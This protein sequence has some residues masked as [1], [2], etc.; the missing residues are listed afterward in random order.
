MTP[1]DTPP[2][3]ATPRSP[4]DLAR[5]EGVTREAVLVN[6]QVLAP[7]IPV[8]LAHVLQGSAPAL[9]GDEQ[10]AGTFVHEE[11]DQLEDGAVGPAGVVEGR[12]AV[13]VNH[14]DGDH[15]VLREESHAVDL[16]AAA[17]RVNDALTELVADLQQ[18]ASL[19]HLLECRDVGG[20]DGCQ[21]LHAVRADVG[22]RHGDEEAVQGEGG[23]LV[24]HPL[25][26][27]ESLEVLLRRD[28]RG[29]RLDGRGQGGGRDALAGRPLLDRRAL[30][31][32]DG[33]PDDGV[34]LVDAVQQRLGHSAGQ[35]RRGAAHEGLAAVDLV[36]DG[37]LDEVRVHGGD[38]G[39]GVVHEGLGQHELVVALH[40]LRG[41][42][43]LVPS[44]VVRLRVL[45]VLVVAGG[46]VGPVAGAVAARGAGGIVVVIV[47]VLLLRHAAHALLLANGLVLAE[48]LQCRLGCCEWVG[49]A[50]CL[51]CSVGFC[52]CLCLRLRCC[53]SLCL[54]Q[55]RV[56]EMMI[57]QMPDEFF[58]LLRIV[59]VD[60]AICD[61]MLVSVCLERADG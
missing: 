5:E 2:K 11:V 49:H 13:V 55:D 16:A 38:G 30:I 51:V 47:D 41:H 15:G 57:M 21:L 17:A 9:V 26:L 53:L 48:L 31:D 37:L 58:C 52:V 3:A 20:A 19:P 40:Q 50:V 32:L 61:A 22:L 39:R 29:D 25:V 10:Q 54:A 35:V 44:R 4:D 45:L 18:L 46:V 60:N 56:H 12:A 7:D 23:D 24:G 36:A 6:V 33:L 34:G 27:D 1:S 43:L 59:N 14:L 8:L 28:L 42:V